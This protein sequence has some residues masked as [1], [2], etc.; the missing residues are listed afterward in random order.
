[1]NPLSTDRSPVAA[2]RNQLRLRRAVR[3]RRAALA[4]D[5]DTFDTPSAL[6]DLS[7]MLARY[8]DQETAGLRATVR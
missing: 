2:V 3:A 7:A 4:R 6:L 1:M 8:P 5:L